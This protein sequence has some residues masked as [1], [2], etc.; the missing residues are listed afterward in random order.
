MMFYGYH[1]VYPYERQHGQRLYFDLELSL[2]LDLAGKSDDL[3]KTVD[4]TKVYD[5]VKG[6][7]ENEQYQLL[8]ALAEKI[9]QEIL[10][11][12]A[13]QSVKIKVRKPLVPVP[14]Q[15]DYMEIEIIRGKSNI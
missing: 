10:L 12:P 6:I 5:V 15:I 8:E 11:F 13:I 1:G 3:T 14:G 7:V 9:A 2:A 4:Y